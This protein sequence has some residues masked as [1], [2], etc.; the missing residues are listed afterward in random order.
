MPGYLDDIK[1]ELESRQINR[2][3]LAVAS[4][5]AGNA[6]VMWPEHFCAGRADQFGYSP[7]VIGVV[8]RK[9]DVGKLHAGLPER[10][11]HRPGI[12]RVNNRTMISTR[13]NEPDIIVGKCGYRCHGNFRHVSL[14][15]AP[16]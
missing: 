5:L 11:S 6:A 14:Q 2:F 9:K 10:F 15:M 12:T 8:V 1:L 4:V 16:I 7:D 13:R 3:S